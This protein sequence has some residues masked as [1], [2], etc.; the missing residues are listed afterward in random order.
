MIKSRHLFLTLLL[1]VFSFQLIAQDTL[2]SS[3][4]ADPIVHTE[5]QTLSQ[6]IDN[7]FKPV[8]EWMTEI[9]FWD[10]FAIAGMHDP[11]IYDIEGNPIT[12]DSG[13]PM[14]SEI[15]FI[16]IWLIL[17]AVTFTIP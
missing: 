13:E 4:E 6:T 2:R 10:P 17:G 16:V 14:R 9:L 5:D 7:A 12:D 8:V 1:F 11:V 3:S 15:P